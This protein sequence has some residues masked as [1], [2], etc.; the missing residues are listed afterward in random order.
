MCDV[1]EINAVNNLCWQILLSVNLSNKSAVRLFP[2]RFFGVSVVLPHVGY[3]MTN[4]FRRNVKI[5]FVSIKVNVSSKKMYG[6]VWL[7][8]SEK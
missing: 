4:G 3:P 1:E 7:L 5:K 2:V 6:P 8:L